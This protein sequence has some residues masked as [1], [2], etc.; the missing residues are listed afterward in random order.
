MSNHNDIT[1]DK[2][3][4]KTN[5]KEYADNYDKIF[6]KA[7]AKNEWHKHDGSELCPVNLNDNIQVET[8]TPNQVTT[9]AYMLH[10]PSVKFY[11]VIKND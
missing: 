8:W 9:V 1:G 7:N 4:S 6:G 10:W 5:T 11:R 2:I 3:I